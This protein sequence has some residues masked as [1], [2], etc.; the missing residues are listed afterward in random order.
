MAWT[1]QSTEYLYQQILG[2]KAHGTVLFSSHILESITLTSDRVF[3]LEEGKIR[4]TFERGQI[5]AD[6][7]RRLCMMK[8]TGKAFAKKLFGAKYERLPRTLFDRCDCILGAVYCRLSGADC[9]VCPDSDD[10]RLYCRRDVAGSFFQ[11]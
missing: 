6:E 8:M 1:F 9:T 2:Y 7:I 5:S 11:R 10:K 3:V 4:R